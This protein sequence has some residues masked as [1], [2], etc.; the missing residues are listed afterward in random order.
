[1]EEVRKVLA[2]RHVRAE[3]LGTIEEILTKNKISFEYI[4]ISEGEK[5]KTLSDTSLIII[6]GGYMGAYE[7]QKYPFLKDEF[8]IVEEAIKRNIPILGICLGDQIL[9]RVLSAN[10]FKG[11]KGKEIGWMKVFR[12]GEKERIFLDFPDEIEV[13][14]WHGDTFEIPK[15]AKRIFSSEKYENQAFTYKNSVGIQFHPEITKEMILE[16][17]KLYRNEI[18]RENISPQKL[19]EVEE[20]HINFLKKLT[21]KMVLNLI[22]EKE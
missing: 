8:K 17:T 20:K 11:E 1:M 15:G 22:N 7:E 5:P 12:S 16:W 10:V 2:I 3:H 9:A 13:F 14:Q 19:L 21:E 4:D 18:E 6:L